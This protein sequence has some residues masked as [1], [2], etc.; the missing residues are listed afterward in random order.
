MPLNRY[1]KP[2]LS[3]QTSSLKRKAGDDSEKKA[4]SL[5]ATLHRELAGSRITASRFFQEVSFERMLADVTE[6]HLIKDRVRRQ[7]FYLKT[8]YGEFFLKRSNLVRTKD[9]MR[10]FILPQRRW[11]EW[12]NLHRLINAQVPAARPL[13]RGQSKISQPKSYFFCGDQ[14]KQHQIVNWGKFS[15]GLDLVSKGIFEQL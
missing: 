6:W 4:G 15:A 13:A 14:V 2:F 5:A 11:A 3:E 7:V 1:K 10:H 8:P 12:R 9:R